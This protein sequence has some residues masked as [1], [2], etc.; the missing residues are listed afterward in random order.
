[1]RSIVGVVFCPQNALRECMDTLSAPSTAP[2]LLKVSQ[3][4]AMLGVGRSTVYDLIARGELETVHIGRSCRI[5]VAALDAYVRRLRDS[6]A[7]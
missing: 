2:L 5:P 3:A 6:A 1:L 7:R 4:G